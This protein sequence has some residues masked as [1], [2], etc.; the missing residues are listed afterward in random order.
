MD[1]FCDASTSAYAAVV[2]MVVKS[3]NG[4]FTRF[5]ASKT[6]I[7]PTQTQTIPR[8]KLLSALL[9]ARLITSITTSLN[10]QF[11]LESPECF[12]DSKVA[13]FWIRDSN[14]EWK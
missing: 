8:L 13:L 10:S 9:L 2:Y 3:T 11:K 7:A 14:K 4:E 6:K 5:I 12:T 1:L